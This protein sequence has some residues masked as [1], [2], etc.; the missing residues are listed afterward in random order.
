MSNNNIE[1]SAQKNIFLNFLHTCETYANKHINDPKK[2]YSQFIN[3]PNHRQVN[4]KGKEDLS[5]QLHCQK[6]IMETML[7][8]MKKESIRTVLESLEL[9]IQKTI[10]NFEEMKKYIPESE[11]EK[12]YLLALEILSPLKKSSI[13]PSPSPSVRSSRS[14]NPSLSMYRKELDESLDKIIDL[15]KKLKDSDE[16]EQEFERQNKD[17]FL[18][19]YDYLLSANYCYEDNLTLHNQKSRQIVSLCKKLVFKYPFSKFFVLMNFFKD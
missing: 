2:K 6:T 17:F 15:L 12:Y 5:F 13:N 14:T 10:A 1:I 19:L 9:D 3:N 4:L 8:T 11:Y 18:R 16:K 7:K